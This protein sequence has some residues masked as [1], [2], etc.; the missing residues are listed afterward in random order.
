MIS[1][2]T[3]IFAFAVIAI[4]LAYVSFTYH[5]IKA[6]PEAPSLNEYDQVKQTLERLAQEKEKHFIMPDKI[7]FQNI[8]A[9]MVK[10]A[11]AIREGS[12]TFMKEEYK[13]ITIVVAILAIIY[14]CIIERL[15]GPMMVFG[16]IMGTC[17]CLLSMAG[18]ISTNVRS[19]YVAFVTGLSNPTLRTM[20]MGGSISGICIAAF[21][22]LGL[23]IVLAF[24]N[25]MDPLMLG[26]G[27]L[28]TF[29]GTR[30]VITRI[31]SYAL[32]CSIV[33]IF[34][35][36]GGGN[37]T[38]AADIGSDK[39]GKIDYDLEEDDSK[40]PCTIADNVGDNVNDVAGNGSDL[41]ESAINSIAASIVTPLVTYLVTGLASREAVMAMINYC[42]ILF[43]IGLLGTVVGV[44]FVLNHKPTKVAAHE[45]DIM[46]YFTYGAIAIGG[47]ILT[48]V[49]FH[50]I[51]LP[52]EFRYGEMSIWYSSMFGNV[53]AILVALLTEYYTSGACKPTQRLAYDA[54]SGE[55]AVASGM[56][57]IGLK[58]TLPIMA[59]IGMAMVGCFYMGGGVGVAIGA[60]AVLASVAAT[61]S[62]DAFGPIADNA[63]G[64]AEMCKLP[65]FVRAITDEHDATGNTKAAVGKGAAIEG[66][67][68]AATSMLISF[69]YGYQAGT[70]VLNIANTIIFVGT[71]I[72]VATIAYFA[73]II[74]QDTNDSSE[75]MAES[76]RRQLK[77]RP[78]I[79]AGTEDPDHKELV[80]LATR[81]AMKKMAFPALLAIV[82][83]ASAGC[84]FGPA[85]AAAVNAGMIIVAIMFAIF[86]GVS[87]GAA[88]NAK[89]LIEAGFLGPEFGKHSDAHKAS[90]CG[91]TI[92]DIFKDCDGPDMDVIVK[93]S[94]TAS[95]TMLPM[96]M[97]VQLFH[98]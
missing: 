14:S 69:I 80:K 88:D 21:G 44:I 38:K 2:S 33:A 57:A 98:I 41:N 29:A 77:E 5:K 95:N 13:I 92:G 11:K 46:N 89:K 17:G 36:I 61:V 51:E 76:A 52:K 25:S 47:L 23:M 49:I 60:V 42:V 54:K 34:N 50:S 53:C 84:L 64:I 74:I 73:A 32:G 22:G 83:S 24:H 40:N 66:A 7:E 12:W 93:I 96:F 28:V 19:A 91:D 9:R 70:P 1:V 85:F 58:S 10:T 67:A 31:T 35:R 26:G 63:G 62:A 72:G 90:V 94:M 8:S 55:A 79:L 81:E 65:E 59:T 27:L 86:F 37:F 97:S 78:G 30:S 3:F 87:G 18:S 71:M 56:F 75:K 68:F 43:F 15:A 4:A 45:L 16:V 39:V 6:M 20:L 82:V 48:F